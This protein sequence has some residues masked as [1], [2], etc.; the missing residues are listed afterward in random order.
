M[1]NYRLESKY[2]KTYKHLEQALEIY[3]DEYEL[4]GHRYYTDTGKIKYNAVAA[5]IIEWCN[6]TFSYEPPNKR[7]ETF[8]QGLGLSIPYSYHDIY[9]LCYQE[10]RLLKTDS[11]NRHQKYA[12]NYW[13]F[14]SMRLRNISESKK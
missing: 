11:E 2:P 3:A 14:M 10:G 12:D 5:E 7:I 9:E 8:L 4:K 1:S 6:E 13:N